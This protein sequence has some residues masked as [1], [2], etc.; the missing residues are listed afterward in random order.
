LGGRVEPTI[1]T[2]AEERVKNPYSIA[3]NGKMIDEWE[4]IR[5]EAAVF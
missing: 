3:L 2:M 5:K 1:L 4:R